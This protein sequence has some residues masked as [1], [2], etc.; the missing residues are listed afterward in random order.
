M[1]KSLLTLTLLLSATLALAESTYRLDVIEKTS[2]SWSGQAI[3]Y[4]ETNHATVTSGIIHIQKNTALPWH[5]HEVPMM[6]F[7]KKG[8]LTLEEKD[9]KTK[10]LTAGQTSVESVNTVHRGKSGNEDVELVA[11]YLGADGKQNT[12]VQHDDH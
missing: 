5:R 8:T 4:P 3:H 12:V 7:V 2:Q 11:F 9:G 1:K 6:I 10:T